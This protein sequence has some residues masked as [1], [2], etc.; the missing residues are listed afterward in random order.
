[1]F[2]YT[3]TEEASVKCISAKGRVDALSSQDIQK[4]FDRLILDGERLLLVDMGGVNYVS[5]AGLRVF[6][7]TQKQLKKVGGEIVLVAMTQ[8]VLEVFE[9]SGLTTVFRTFAGK[10][11]I[12]RVLSK[13]AGE[14]SFTAV[15]LKGMHIE[16]VERGSGTSPLVAIGSQEKN[17][18]SS[19]TEDDVVPVKASEVQFG[20]GFAALGDRYE[21]YKGLFGESMVVDGNFFFFPAVRH[22]SVD[23]LIGAG[24]ESGTVYRFFHGF[25]FNGP[26]RY[27]LSFEAVD[28]P[29]DLASLTEGFLDIFRSDIL[30]IVI[31]AESKGVWGM[32]VK[33]VPLLEQKPQNGKSI[34]DAENFAEWVDFPVEPAYAD[35]VVVATGIVV[36]DPPAMKPE[37][38][39]LVAESSKFHVHG[40]I[41]EKAPLSKDIG[42]FDGELL[43]IFNE[44][45]VHKV[46]HLLGRSTFSGGMAAVIGL[47][48]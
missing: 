20:C 15:N 5:S 34:F 16:Y 33:K 26:Y 17:A 48:A 6:L 40:G 23:F 3:I 1:M 43:R 11:E 42:S 2:E 18:A 12:R 9:M 19:Y 46:Q 31:V 37:M 35:H 4:A 10:E 22:S 14:G 21:E 45:Q 28:R 32:H 29:V 38:R 41:F 36:R 47:E 25:G 44:L 13:D 8:P 39:S 27:L 7:S 30:G 24:R